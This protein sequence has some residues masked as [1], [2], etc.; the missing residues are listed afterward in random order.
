M[1]AIRTGFLSVTYVC[2]YI[3]YLE[4]MNEVYS[5]QQSDANLTYH[6]D[7]LPES[8]NTFILKSRGLRSF[9]LQSKFPENTC[10]DIKKR[11]LCHGSCKG[12]HFILTEAA[13]KYIL[14]KTC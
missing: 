6:G 9:K 4:K 14:L 13:V 1:G 5:Y 12:H 8:V 10:S 11:V 2:R 3:S 7:L